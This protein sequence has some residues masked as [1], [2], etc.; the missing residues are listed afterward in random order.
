[1]DEE[2]KGIARSLVWWKPSE[3]VDLRYLARRAMELGTPEMVAVVR[4]KLGEPFLREALV[5]AEPGNF[6]E[7][8]W[9][10]WHVAFGIRP[11]PPLPTRVVPDSPHVSPEIRRSAS[12][13]AGAVAQAG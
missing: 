3:T 1:M 9:N 4:G 6:S 5:T 12:R 13:P 2:L 7:R 8:S 11:T 10:Y